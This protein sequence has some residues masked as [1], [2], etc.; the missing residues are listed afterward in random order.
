MFIERILDTP[1]MSISGSLP[2]STFRFEPMNHYALE[3]DRFSRLLLGHDV[4]T[5]PIEDAVH[6]LRTIEALLESGRSGSWQQLSPWQNF[7]TE[8]KF[9]AL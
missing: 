5:W 9:T 6:T 1:C 2:T 7:G 4:P 3:V 8:T